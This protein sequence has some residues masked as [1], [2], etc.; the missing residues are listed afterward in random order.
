MKSQLAIWSPGRVNLIGEHI[1]YCGGAVL[2]MTLQFGTRIDIRAL[3]APLIRA[4]SDNEAIRVEVSLEAPGGGGTGTWAD[5][6]VGVVGLLGEA[7]TTLRGADVHIA[8]NIPA[9]GLSSSASLTCG[10]AYGLDRFNDGGLSRLSL[11]K[12]ARAVEHRYAGVE[13]G[14]MDQAAILLSEADSA[15]YFDC[16]TCA[17]R[18]VPVPGP[19]DGVAFVVIDSGKPRRLA[20][21]GYNERL[22]EV[23]SIAAALRAPLDNLARQPLARLD[24]GLDL[25]ARLGARLRHQLTEQ[26]RVE[27]AVELLREGQ[28]PDLG[29]LFSESHCSLRDDY[30][31]SCLELDTLVELVEAQPGCHGAR[32]TGAGFG[33]AVVA[34]IETES[35]TQTMAAVTRSYRQRLGGEA[36]WFIAR[37]GGGVRVLD[38]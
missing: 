32:M 2:P 24:D 8:G 1:D 6:V 13:C 17:V 26:A 3:D 33:G 18:S 19:E 34:L 5:F 11:A 14:L 30:E 38:Q 22:A 23:R 15:L 20:A 12:L 21:V 7:G 31:V 37:P 35:V 27:A 10:L 28:W 9:S 29:R 36:D 16:A 25:D 4:T